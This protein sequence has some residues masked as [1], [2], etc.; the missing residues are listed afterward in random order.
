MG[1]S[2]T[3]SSWLLDLILY[4]SNPFRNVVFMAF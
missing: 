4:D 1:Q 2:Q 3:I